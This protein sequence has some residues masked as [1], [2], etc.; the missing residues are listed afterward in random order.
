MLSPDDSVCRARIRR[1]KPFPQGDDHFITLDSYG[2]MIPCP[3]DR[4]VAVTPHDGR[5]SGEGRGTG[6]CRAGRNDPGRQG[7]RAA[8][9]PVPMS[10]SGR[11]GIKGLAEEVTRPP[12]VKTV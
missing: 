3:G 7:S 9:V 11:T 10:P 8:Q 4:D 1:R 5:H 2:E 6:D 12:A